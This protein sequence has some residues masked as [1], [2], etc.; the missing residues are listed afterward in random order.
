MSDWFLMNI[1]AVNIGHYRSLIVSMISDWW[2]ITIG[3]R[4]SSIMNSVCY[5]CFLITRFCKW[6]IW[7]RGMSECHK[8]YTNWIEHKT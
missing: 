6:F 7:N 4:Y 2:T 3:L 8:Y 1:T 5:Q